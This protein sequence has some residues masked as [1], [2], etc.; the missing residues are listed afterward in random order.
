MQNELLRVA[1]RI[2]NAVVNLSFFPAANPRGF[3]LGKVSSHREGRIRQIERILL[4]G[5]FVLRHHV[6]PDPLGLFS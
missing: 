5:G 4:V 6:S 2:D 1:A 3:A